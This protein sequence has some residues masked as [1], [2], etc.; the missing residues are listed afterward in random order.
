MLRIWVADDRQFKAQAVVVEMGWWDSQ[1]H[2]INGATET[3]GQPSYD[4][5]VS[6]D[7]V[8]FIQHLRTVSNVPIYFLSVPWMSP[9][10][11]PNGQEDPGATPAS[12]QE[13]N[14]V[15]KAATQSASNVHFIDVTP[16]VTPSGQYQTDVGGQVCRDPDGVHMYTTTGTG[17]YVATKCG[18]ALQ[19]GVLSTIRSALAR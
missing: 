5:L 19:S 7:I 3:L 11:W 10:L 4:A 17:K 15:I 12:H 1:P 8:S 16:Y 14:A 13:I 2:L 9:S 6:Q 18:R